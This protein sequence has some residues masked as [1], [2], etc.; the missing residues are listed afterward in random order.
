MKPIAPT[1]GDVGEIVFVFE[2]QHIAK[3]LCP[4]ERIFRIQRISMHDLH[5][6]KAD[7]RRFDHQVKL[8]KLQPGFRG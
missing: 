2:A 4:H 5:V 7:I 3:F 8:G 6:P 1:A